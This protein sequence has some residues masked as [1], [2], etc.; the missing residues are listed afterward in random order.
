MKK[1]LLIVLNLVFFR[2]TLCELPSCLNNC[3][4]NEVFSKCGGGLC[5]PNTWKGVD[6][7]CPCTPGCVC[8]PGYAR[9]PNTYICEPKEK[10]PA[11]KPGQCA[12]NEEWSDSLAG[13]QKSCY[14]MNAEFKCLPVPGCVCKEGFIRCS[15]F[16]QCIPKEKCQTC[17]PGYSKDVHTFH[18]NFCCQ[19]CPENEEYNECGTSCES[20][21]KTTTVNKPCNK[22]CKVGC[23]CKNGYV[24][25]DTSGKCIPKEWCKS[26]GNGLDNGNELNFKNDDLFIYLFS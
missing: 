11:I 6:E 2:N 15:I 9:D 17:P 3:P 19:E 13:C 4:V 25:D 20:T 12:A 8:K 14:T 22:M 26:K 7:N 1:L 23:F 10:C 24:R 18:C 16:G 5:E 21:C